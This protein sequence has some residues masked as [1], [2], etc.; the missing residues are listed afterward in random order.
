MNKA[1]VYFLFV[2]IG[3]ALSVLLVR[4]FSL[5]VVRNSEFSEISR[6]QTQQRS[7]LFSQRGKVLDASGNVLIRNLDQQLEPKKESRTFL[8][9]QKQTIPWHHLNARRPQRV[10]PFEDIGGAI[11]GYCGKD[12]YGLSG[13][14]YSFDTELRGEDGWTIWQRD[15]LNNKYQKFGNPQKHPINGPDLTLTL[16][17][18]IQKIVQH[19]LE[20]RVHELSAKGGLAIMMDPNNGEILALAQAPA[21][22][23]NTPKRYPV[24]DRR[25]R[26]INFIYEPGSTFK[27]ITAA[28]ALQEKMVE[29]ETIIDGADGAYKVYDQVIRDRKPFGQISVA[30]ALQYSSNVCFAKIADKLGD[31]RL[32][33]YANN[34]GFGA[35]TGVRLPGEEAGILH[36][37]SQWSGRTLATMAIGQEISVTFMQMVVAMSAAINGGVLPKPVIQKSAA[38]L[39]PQQNSVRRVISRDVSKSIR[40][41]LERVVSDGTAKSARIKDIPMGGKTGTSQKLDAETRS[42][43]SSKYW[44]SFI[45]F[46]PVEKPLLICGV[47]ID[48]PLNGEGGGTAA[49][50]AFKQIIQQIIS[51]PN[52][53]YAK[54]I[55]PTDHIV[56][57]Q[58]SDSH[59]S[60]QKKPKDSI[61][62]EHA[63]IEIKGEEKVSSINRFAGFMKSFRKNRESINTQI[64][65][66]EINVPNCI[67]KD[68]RNAIYD[69]LASGI[70]PHIK[71]RGTVTRQFPRVGSM[72]KST[73]ACTLYCAV[74][75]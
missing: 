18:E 17:I 25:N 12:G 62:I 49:G 43:S 67:G 72:I 75:G 54:K 64:N 4:L 26:C 52:L 15:G 41:M 28:A 51:S 8:R 69:L 40:F 35:K 45:G 20:K 73:Q 50:P 22:N 42:Y 10:Y 21:F 74:E 23:P 29:A 11:L 24:I 13:V 32:Y 60:S 34:F 68:A 55:L 58:K 48:E 70:E 7:V 47:L 6:I 2:C 56:V 59:N 33:H 46:V 37:I 38:S 5:Q 9:S 1:R 63:K 61:N 31:K 3:I 27:V 66:D 57:A 65:E 14:E 71:G 36:P 16:D 44:S 30:E 39:S 19:V 53:D